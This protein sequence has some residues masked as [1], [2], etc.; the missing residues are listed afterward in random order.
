[1][2]DWDAGPLRGR[3]AQLLPL[4]EAVEHPLFTGFLEVDRQLVTFDR[5]DASVAE[6]LVEDAFTEREAG[7]AGDDALR[8]QLS[9]DQ[10]L[11]RFRAGEI[12]VAAHRAF[13]AAV[14]LG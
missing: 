13:L 5:S 3:I 4:D 10:A 7:A 1:M 11:L 2:D 9:F 12:A 14:L 6:L 8:H